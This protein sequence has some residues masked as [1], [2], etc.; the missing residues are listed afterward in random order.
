MTD[1]EHGDG[2][3]LEQIERR[4]LFAM[5]EE[6]DADDAMDIVGSLSGRVAAEP[7]ADVTLAGYIE[8][9]DRVPAFD[10]SDGQPYTVDIATDETGDGDRPFSAFLVFVRWAQ[11]GAGIMDH[12]E[13]GDLA[14][15]ATA[16]EAK[17]AIGELS[18]YEV[19]AELDAAI[20]RKRGRLEG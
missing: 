9:H 12:T 1:E 6:D 16:D 3:I 7:A 19:K 13:S 17:Q 20:E 10:G 2:E 4:A 5:G 14:F 15:G 18:L 11:T 8:K